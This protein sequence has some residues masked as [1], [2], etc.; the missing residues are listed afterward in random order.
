M[1]HF[2]AKIG[3]DRV[4]DLVGDHGLGNRNDKG[5]RLD[6]FCQQNN[7]VATNTWLRHHSRRLYIWTS[8]QH[9]NVR[10]VQNQIDFIMVNERYHNAVI[11]ART[12]P[13]A[14]IGSVIIL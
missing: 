5:D 13:D 14:D 11:D 4:L 3:Q 9:N 1:G 6:E 7:M 12:Y 8:P 10:V 2:N